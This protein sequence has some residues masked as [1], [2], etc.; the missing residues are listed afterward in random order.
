[1]R[2]VSVPLQEIYFFRACYLAAELCL[3]HHQKQQNSNRISA[4]IQ[5]WTQRKTWSMDVF[6]YKLRSLNELSCVAV[7]LI[8]V[9]INRQIGDIDEDEAYTREWHTLQE[10]TP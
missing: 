9:I 10:P 8:N 2:Y 7:F 3:N 6:F 5:L 4:W 1:M